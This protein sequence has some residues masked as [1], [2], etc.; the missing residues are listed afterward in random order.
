MIV[1]ET[2]FILDY[3]VRQLII[4]GLGLEKFPT[5]DIDLLPYGMD[6]CLNLLE[7]LK[8]D[9][10]SKKTIPTLPIKYSSEFMSFLDN[11]K[12]YLDTIIEIERA[13]YK[14]AKHKI[15]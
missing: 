14:I 3:C 7:K 6:V 13:Y 4:S 2:W 15:S 12:N 8:K 5:E 9:Q 1:L 11:N 10:L